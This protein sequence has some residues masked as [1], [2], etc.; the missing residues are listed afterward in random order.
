[1][2]HSAFINTLLGKL[3]TS[4]FLKIAGPFDFAQGKL[5][6]FDTAR[7]ARR[8]RMTNAACAEVP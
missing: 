3:C 1:M 8:L 2:R 4:G 6:S 5:R 7:V